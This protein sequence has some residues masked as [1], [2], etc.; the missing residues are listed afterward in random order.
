MRNVFDDFL[1]FVPPADERHTQ[2]VPKCKT[3]AARTAAFALLIELVRDCAPNYC[4]L[5]K[6]LMALHRTE[7]RTCVDTHG[8]V[9]RHA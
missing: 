2:G 9:C 3:V 7:V 4:S 6:Q 8:P 5:S 1:F